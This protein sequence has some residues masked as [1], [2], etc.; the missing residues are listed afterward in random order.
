M[1]FIKFTLLVLLT[2]FFNGLQAQDIHWTLYQMSPLTLNPAL[3]GSYEGTARVGGIFRSQG[4]STTDFD[5]YNT[6]SFYGD[7]PLINIGKTDWLGVGGMLYSDK[8]GVGGL[9]ST[10]AMLSI[11]YHKALDKKR[12]TV[13]S[14]GIQGGLGQRRF[15]NNEDVIFASDIEFSP[16]FGMMESLEANKSYFDLNAGV[17]LKTQM[18]KTSAMR[19]GM[20]FSHILKP[21][22]SLKT[23][24]QNNSKLPLRFQLHAGFDFDLGKK[25]TL[26]PAA[27]YNKI[28]AATEIQAQGL[29]KYKINPEKKTNLLFG[30][31]YRLGDA[32]QVLMGIEMKTL[33]VMASYD[34]TLSSL[35]DI[36]NSVGGFEI[37]A[38]YIIQIYKEPVVKPVIFCP[39]F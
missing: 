3:T 22:Y 12:K 29:L 25:W 39:R 28:S 17:L 27:L 21:N 23:G 31:G 5:G 20:S 13:L 18:N 24:N 15:D 35:A 14:F 26:S 1:R 11:A 30:P 2:S 9:G 16:D 4:F 8:A 19:L 32:L 34:V 7:A 6:P 10:V 33:K 38:S 36:N 37:A